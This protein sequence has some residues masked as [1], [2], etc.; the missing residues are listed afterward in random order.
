MFFGVCRVNFGDFRVGNAVCGGADLRTQ[1]LATKLA[2][3]SYILVRAGDDSKSELL[4]KQGKLSRLLMRWKNT[5]WRKVLLALLSCCVF[6]AL[7]GI[8][9]FL[10][11]GRYC[12]RYVGAVG[13]PYFQ[14]TGGNVYS[15]VCGQR[16]LEGHYRRTAS[17]W[18]AISVSRDGTTNSSPLDLRWSRVVMGE[19]TFPRCWHFWMNSHGPLW[20]PWDK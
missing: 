11:Q 2:S 10:A 15:V 7:V 4:L 14:F 3:C 13:H 18:E 17:G 9:L 12:N 19:L 1:R 20:D 6:G 8:G 16:K 5:R